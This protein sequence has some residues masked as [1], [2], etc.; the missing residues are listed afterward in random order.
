M[1]AVLYA[2]SLDESEMR[3]DRCTGVAPGLLGARRRP[4]AYAGCADDVEAIVVLWYGAGCEPGGL[5][6][7]RVR[8][9]WSSCWRLGVSG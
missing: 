5:R 7:T 4:R 9:R 2:N 3:S 6:W 8:P 1:I